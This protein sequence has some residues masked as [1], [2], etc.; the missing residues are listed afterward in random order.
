MAR[1]I[2]FYNDEFNRI[3]RSDGVMSIV[4]RSAQSI[5][6]KCGSGFIVR[7][8]ESNWSAAGPSSRRAC[9]VGPNTTEAREREA[10]DKVLEKAVR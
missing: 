4:R 5:K 3:L 7:E 2:K 1:K 6:S 10:T 9:M 8:V